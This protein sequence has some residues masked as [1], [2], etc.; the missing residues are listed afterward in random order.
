LSVCNPSESSGMVPA[1]MEL[2]RLPSVL[3]VSDLDVKE[4]TGGRLNDFTAAFNG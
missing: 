4:V 2:S 3:P 1:G